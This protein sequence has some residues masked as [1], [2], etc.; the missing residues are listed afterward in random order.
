MSQ[1][2]KSDIITLAFG[3]LKTKEF[4]EKIEVKKLVL[5]DIGTSQKLQIAEAIGDL[6]FPDELEAETLNGQLKLIRLEDTIL[7]T[8]E[9]SAEITLQCDRCLENFK[10]KIEFTL[11][12]E[13]EINRQKETEENLY[14]DKYLLIDISEPIR[15][16]LL[17]AIPMKNICKEDCKGIDYKSQF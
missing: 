9:F 1:S 17:M 12:R 11:E 14:V 4:M 7:V 13:Y 8:G 16:E 3:N 5:G 2:K 10:K 6:D 15:E